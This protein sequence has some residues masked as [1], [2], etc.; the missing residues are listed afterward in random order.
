MFDLDAA[1]TENVNVE[2][3]MDGDENGIEDTIRVRS[4][5]GRRSGPKVPL[6]VH[7]SP[8]FYKGGRS[9]WETNFFVPRGYAVATVALPGTDFSTGCSDVG[10]DLEVLGHQGRSS[11]G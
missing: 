6:I 8:Y 2:T 10:A 7:A 1:I 4:S 5:A 9:D 11:T 3:G